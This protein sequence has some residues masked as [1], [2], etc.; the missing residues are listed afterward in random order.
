MYVCMYLPYDVPSIDRSAAARLRLPASQPASQP[1]TRT[2][3]LIK[4]PAKTA[5]AG[6]SCELHR[7]K[8]K[9]KKICLPA[10]LS[11]QLIYRASGPPG[12][13]WVVD[14][15]VRGRGGRDNNSSVTCLLPFR[16]ASGMR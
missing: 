10:Y 2:F 13:Y 4:I 11:G 14:V 16:L 15:N 6:H 5:R 8:S 9:R 3:R 1:S 7:V 12:G